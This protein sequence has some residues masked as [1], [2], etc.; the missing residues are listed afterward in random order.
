MYPA[1]LEA[2][3]EIVY[4][5]TEFHLINGNLPHPI[6]VVLYEQRARRVTRLW[7]W[8]RRPP[9]RRQDKL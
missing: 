2:F 9:H 5:D 3:D 7:L 4:G 6:C 1:S 8:G